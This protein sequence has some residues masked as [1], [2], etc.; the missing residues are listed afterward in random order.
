[1]RTSALM[2]PSKFRLP[3]STAATARPW[4]LTAAEIS[5]AS[6]PEFPMHVVQP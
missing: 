4:S 1:M 6:G 3:D 2:R 5:G